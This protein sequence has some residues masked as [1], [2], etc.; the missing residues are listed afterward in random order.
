MNTQDPFNWTSSSA[1][2]EA[3]RTVQCYADEWLVREL[4]WALEAGQDSTWE[5]QEI[6]DGRQVKL[7]DA[8]KISEWLSGQELN[9]TP[10]HTL[11]D[12]GHWEYA[13]LVAKTAMKNHL[14]GEMEYLH[15][16]YPPFETDGPQLAENDPAPIYPTI[17]QRP[18]GNLC[19]AMPDIQQWLDTSLGYESEIS[20]ML[21]VEISYNDLRMSQQ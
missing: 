16:A 21:E 6:S 17:G 9:G 13:N 14:L 19:T 11:G 5:T 2:Y 10:I 7:P 8:E 1:A 18:N 3:M 4:V 20:K 15:R 12:T